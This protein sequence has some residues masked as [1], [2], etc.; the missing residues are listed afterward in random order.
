MHSKG[1]YKLDEAT[2]ECHLGQIKAILPS[3]ARG[4]G[5]SKTCWIKEE[6]AD[7]FPPRGYF[8][9]IQ[10]WEIKTISK[11]LFIQYPI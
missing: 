7:A 5:D 2:G 6:V 3:I 11:L 10:L 4:K 8:M 9:L 1:A